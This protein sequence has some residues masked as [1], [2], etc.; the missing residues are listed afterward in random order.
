MEREYH[1]NDPKSLME[2][3]SQ[4]R[5][6]IKHEGEHIYASWEDHI[7]RNAFKESAL[8][9]SYYLALRNR[10]IT[11]IQTDLIP[12][13]LSSLGR[14]ESKT[15][16]T[17]DAVIATLH[18]VIDEEI[19]HEHPEPDDFDVG[20]RR[21]QKNTKKIFGK[22]PDNRTTRIMVTMPN[23]AIDDAQLIYD[24]VSEGMN[25]A[26]INCAHNKPEEWLQMIENIRMASDKLDRDVRILMD[27]AGPKIRT[28]WVYTH[29][30]RP[31]VK[32]GDKIRITRDFDRLPKNDVNFTAG[33][34]ID[35]IYSQIE[36]GQAVLY[37]DG[38]IE[39]K[40]I[41]A[42]TDEFLLEVTKIK[43]SSVRVHPEKGLNFPNNL[44]EFEELTEKDQKDI[45]FACEHA[46]IIGCSFVNSGRDIEL[47][48]AEIAKKL[49][50][51]AKKMSLMAKIETVRATRNLP[52]MI[53]TA[54]SKN[55]FS[56]MIARGDLAAE[57]GYIDLA[58][59][60]QEIMWISEAGDIPVVWA[61]EVLDTLVSDGIPT[62]SEVTDAA[63]GT[64]ADCIMLNKG[65]FIREG[66]NTLNKIIERMEPIQYKKTPI[67]G[68]L[69]LNH[70]S[71]DK[72]RYKK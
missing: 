68:K 28:E 4:L 26:R 37:D 21:L 19:E 27:I 58:A 7:D 43:G 33:C 2:E 54:A 23:E 41:E 44:F 22:K 60:Q 25:V 24:L 6:D 11:Q 16:V 64:R 50:D 15:L 30:R 5:N 40:V 39:S 31:K 55:P 13:G 59:F 67:L 57:S 52:E 51:N 10:D 56:V 61:T 32:P 14:L 70:L 12:W 45:D 62:R 65:D 71:R 20:R 34:E 72:E 47:I 36:V 17:L 48:Q 1:T 29:K 38:S 66:V 49:G 42:S 53:F 18:D 46:D 35:E 3:L 63:E 9:L 8:N 69:K